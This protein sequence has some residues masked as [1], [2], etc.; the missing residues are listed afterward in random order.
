[1]GGAGVFPTALKEP[2]DKTVLLHL[3][4]GRLICYSLGLSGK[5]YSTELDHENFGINDT[6]N[7]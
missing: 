5:P 2:N 7:D 4:F 1:M 3:A 6:D